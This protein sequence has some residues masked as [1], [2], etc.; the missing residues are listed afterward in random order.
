MTEVPGDW[1]DRAY[2]LHRT[3]SSNVYMEGRTIVNP[4]GRK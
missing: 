1:L 3:A 4:G 2:L